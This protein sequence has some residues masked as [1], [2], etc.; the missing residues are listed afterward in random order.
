MLPTVIA[1]SML[2]TQTK[3]DL[4]ND[5]SVHA[6]NIDKYCF[7]AAATSIASHSTAVCKMLLTVLIQRWLSATEYFN[8]KHKSSFHT[9]DN[10]VDPC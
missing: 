3:F 8:S 9:V 1:I 10:K 4:T 5:L 2:V 7:T 6:L